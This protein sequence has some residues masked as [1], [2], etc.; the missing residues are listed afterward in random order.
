LQDGSILE[1]TVTLFTAENQSPISPPSIPGES[2]PMAR[3]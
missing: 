3:G 2:R 1:I